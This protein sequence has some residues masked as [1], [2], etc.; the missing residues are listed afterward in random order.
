MCTVN[1]LLGKNKIVMEKN[2]NIPKGLEL[3][4]QNDKERGKMGLGSSYHSATY[5]AIVNTQI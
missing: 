1:K 3:M 4:L 2:V 5:Q